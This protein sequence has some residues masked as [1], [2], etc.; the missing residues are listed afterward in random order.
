[1]FEHAMS[2]SLAESIS[3]Q[4]ISMLRVQTSGESDFFKVINIK[5]LAFFCFNVSFI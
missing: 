3:F 5:Q 2:L 1:M 4:N